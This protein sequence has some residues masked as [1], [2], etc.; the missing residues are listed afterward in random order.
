MCND[1][2]L[3]EYIEDPMAEGDTIGYQKILKRFK[4]AVPRV[5]IGVKNW[6]KSNID[7]IKHH[8]QI[9]IKDEDEEEELKKKK[10][11]EKKEEVKEE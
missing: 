7:T 3:L 9:I 10:E 4:D 2:P 11:E 8:T 6:F 1:H 5:K